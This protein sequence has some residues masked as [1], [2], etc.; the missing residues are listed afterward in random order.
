MHWYC[1]H[2]IVIIVPTV[3]WYTVITVPVICEVPVAGSVGLSVW[4]LHVLSVSAR[5]LPLFSHR[6]SPKTCTWV[7]WELYIGQWLFVFLCGPA[8]RWPARPRR[9]G[10]APGTL[11]AGLGRRWTKWVTTTCLVLFL[12]DFLNSLRLYRTHYGG[13]PDQLCVSE[14]AS[15]DGLSCWNGTDAVKR[16]VAQKAFEFTFAFN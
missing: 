5:V 9:Q 14:L 2:C 15:S 13:L 16:F 10:L 1:Y 8:I 12:R 3:Q 11:S 7:K 6:L 4:T